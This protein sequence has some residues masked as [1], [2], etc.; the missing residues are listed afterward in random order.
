MHMQTVFLNGT[1]SECVHN[2][3]APGREKLV[4]KTGKKSSGTEQEPVW[5]AP[6]S[7]RVELYHRP[8]HSAQGVHTYSLRP[9]RVHEGQR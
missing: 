6:V 1:L 7:S 4:I 2:F 9:L 5:D 8:R 3:Q